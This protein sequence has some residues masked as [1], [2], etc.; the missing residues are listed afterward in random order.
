MKIYL[1][2]QFVKISRYFVFFLPFLIFLSLFVLEYFFGFEPCGMCV[3]ARYT[4]LA[5]FLS[6][7]LPAG[8]LRRVAGFAVSLF[9]IF[10]SVYHKLLQLGFL[11]KCLLARSVNQSYENFQNMLQN[12][13]PCS[14]KSSLLGVD[15]VWLN[16]AIFIIYAL[17]FLFFLSSAKCVCFNFS[18]NFSRFTRLRF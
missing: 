15:F 6:L 11:T 18:R 1:S 2:R 9:G 13:T 10:V 17:L 4:Y 8:G 7:C 5:L 12:T 3:I 14:V 16:I